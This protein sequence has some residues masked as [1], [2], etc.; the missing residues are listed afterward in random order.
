MSQQIAIR[1][2]DHDLEALDD[3]VAQGRFPNRAAAVREALRRLL[4]DERRRATEAA[5]TRGYGAAPQEEWVGEAGLTGFASLVA[6]EERDE[7]PL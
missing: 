6:V 1:I 2:P 7:D 3:A 4:R 5:D